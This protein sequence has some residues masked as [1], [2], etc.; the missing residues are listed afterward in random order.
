MNNQ[1]ILD[2]LAE[3]LGNLDKEFSSLDILGSEEEALTRSI[4]IHCKAVCFLDAITS[5]KGIYAF[6][7][8]TYI[9]KFIMEILNQYNEDTIKLQ[10]L[11]SAHSAKKII[12]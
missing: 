4:K 7:Y 5:I 6:P 1:D 11:Q 12:T 2:L 3:K 9:D 10:R 8:S